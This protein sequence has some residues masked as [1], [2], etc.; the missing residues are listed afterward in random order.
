MGGAAYSTP[1]KTPARSG[2]VPVLALL[3]AAAQMVSNYYIFIYVSLAGRGFSLRRASFDAI[4]VERDPGLF[5]PPWKTGPFDQSAGCEAAP[6][7]VST[8][9]ESPVP[10]TNAGTPIAAT[11]TCCD[12]SSAGQ[13]YGA[14]YAPALPGAGTRS[15]IRDSA[16]GHSVARKDLP[17]AKRAAL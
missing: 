4:D 7:S 2:A 5:T 14:R 13:S 17:R 10:N 3:L 11:S 12:Q 8:F 1:E 15:A 16:C 9:L 6:T